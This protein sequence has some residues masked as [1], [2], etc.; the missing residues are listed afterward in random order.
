[1]KHLLPITLLAVALVAADKPAA[2]KAT[3]KKTDKER[4][5]GTWVFEALECDGEPVKQGGLYNH[6]KD[7]KWTFKDGGAATTSNDP[8]DKATYTM[9]AAKKPATLDYEVKDKNKALHL[10]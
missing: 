10:L 7:Q 4:I 9:D 3:E 1:M 6:V 5:Q 8:D 2:D